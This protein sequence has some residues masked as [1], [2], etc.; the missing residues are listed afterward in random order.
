MLRSGNTEGSDQKLNELKTELN[1]YTTT[2]QEQ[3]T[4]KK[5]TDLLFQLLNSLE[6]REAE[7]IMGIFR[8]DQGVTGLNY[9][10]VKEAFPDMLP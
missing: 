5:R 3:L 9:K 8:K 7:I 10:F 6:P 1:G 4:E 2:Y